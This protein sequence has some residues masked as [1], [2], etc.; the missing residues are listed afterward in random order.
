MISSMNNLSDV[1]QLHVGG[2]RLDKDPRNIFLEG[3]MQ[4]VRDNF[5]VNQGTFLLCFLAHMSTR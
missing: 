2:E 4:D 1:H 5:Q 3:T